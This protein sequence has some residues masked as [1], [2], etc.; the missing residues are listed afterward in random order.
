VKRKGK[1]LFVL[2]FTE[3]VHADILNPQ[4]ME[5]LKCY[6]ME[7]FLATSS[8]DKSDSDDDNDEEEVTPLFKLKL[9]V[10]TSS[11]GIPC[12]K[13]AGIPIQIIER[14]QEVK[15]NILGGKTIQTSKTEVLSDPHHRLI[16][17]TF[18]ETEDWMKDLGSDQV[19]I[20]RQ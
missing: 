12:A 5:C 2:H 16:L 3:I 6:T 7:T 13:K 18:L 11:E 17:R 14:S 8:K 10:A 9:G 15:A 1:A 20:F 4:D 19:A